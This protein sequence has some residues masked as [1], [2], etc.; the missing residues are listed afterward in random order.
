MRTR[1]S[2]AP[3]IRGPL[4]ESFYASFLRT[5]TRNAL[6]APIFRD[7]YVTTIISAGGDKFY[8]SRFRATLSPRR[9][10]T[11]GTRPF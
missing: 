4:R 5:R 6:F 9:L 10:Q 11:R 2:R 3:F 8:A 1:H 7:A